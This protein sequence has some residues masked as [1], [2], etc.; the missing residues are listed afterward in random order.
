MSDLKVMFVCLGNICRS[1]LAHAIFEK[2][3]EEAGLNILTESC[4]MGT[5]H[6]GDPADPRMRRTAQDHGVIIDHYSRRFEPS[7]LDEYDLIIPMDK[8]NLKDIRAYATSHHEEKIHLM[9]E[10][11][12][13]GG[14]DVPDPWYGGPEG[15]EAVYEIVDRSCR[16][17]V[18]KLKERLG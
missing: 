13:Q 2:R 15:F 8:S 4:G 1:P 12:P 9:R 11:D 14:T 10:W 7:D 3:A 17:L 5:W 6:L 16:V 18:D